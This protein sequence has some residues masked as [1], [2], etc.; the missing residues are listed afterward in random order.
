[1]PE[2]GRVLIWIGSILIVLGLLLSYTHVFD[3]LGRLPG[4]IY[5]EGENVS[6]YFPLTTCLLISLMVSLIG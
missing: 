5:W 4:D 1:M 3:Y 2:P 6:L